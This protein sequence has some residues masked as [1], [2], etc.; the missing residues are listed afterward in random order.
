MLYTSVAVQ[1]Y[2]PN[3]LDHSTSIVAWLNTTS[4]TASPGTCPPLFVTCP[5]D[6]P[7]CSPKPVIPSLLAEPVPGP[8]P[9]P[10]AV[11]LCDLF[12]FGPHP[13]QPAPE[14]A[15]PAHT[16]LYCGPAPY[17]CSKLFRWSASSYS[18]ASTQALIFYLI[19]SFSSASA[20]VS[21]TRSTW[22]LF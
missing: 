11:A 12:E 2:F 19:S 18:S 22:A 16:V 15:P 20:F 10:E 13:P 21:H 5:Y 6:G 14:L 17:A 9:P 4:L 8:H 7:R 1:P 3:P